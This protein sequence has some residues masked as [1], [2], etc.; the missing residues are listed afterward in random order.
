MVGIP[1]L[2]RRDTDGY[3]YLGT[4]IKKVESEKTSFLVQ[5]T[6]LFGVEDTTCVQTTASSDILEYVNGM[7]H[8]ILPGDK[9]LAPWEPEQKRYGPGTVTLGIENRDPLRA[10]EDEEITV[11]FWNGKKVRVPLGVALWI[12]PTQWKRIVEMIHMPLS[13]RKKFEGQH[14]QANCHICSFRPVPASLHACTLEGLLKWQWPYYPC[15]SPSHSCFHHMC[16][17]LPHRH[18]VCCCYYF[19]PRGWSDQPSSA[20]F[21]VGDIKE[22]SFSSKLFPQQLALEGPAKDQSAVATSGS[23]SCS[24]DSQSGETQHVTKTTMVDHAVNTD[25]T[26]FDKPKPKESR[27]PDWK[28]WKRS[29]PNSFYN[30]QGTNIW[31]GCEKKRAATCTISYMDRSPTALMNQSAMFENIEQSPRRPLTVK[32]IL[33]GEDIKLFSG[34]G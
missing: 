29:H 5:F 23:S 9:V 30:S 2:A 12:P 1:I 24:S 28:Y 18:Y 8:S 17:L 19:K 15:T 7:K 32:E 3:Y 34:G 27:R 20:E 10:K 13:S 21:S 11:S 22:D 16:S 26:L 4:I 6:K 14:H 33:S 31:S 25:S